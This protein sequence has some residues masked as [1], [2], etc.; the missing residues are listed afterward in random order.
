MMREM[1]V[2]IDFLIFKDRLR[3]IPNEVDVSFG[4]QLRSKVKMVPGELP[5]V[6]Q[7]R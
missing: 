1:Y 3:S 7:A 6:L 2:L 4:E 5:R